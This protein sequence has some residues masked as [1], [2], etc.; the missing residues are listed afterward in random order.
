[1]GSLEMTEMFVCKLSFLAVYRCTFLLYD[2]TKWKEVFQFVFCKCCE[3]PHQV[4]MYISPLLLLSI[5]KNVIWNSFQKH[6]FKIG[7][8]CWIIIQSKNTLKCTA[9]KWTSQNFSLIKV[10]RKKNKDLLS[11][12]IQQTSTI[13]CSISPLLL[14][15]NPSHCTR[16]HVFGF[17]AL[18][19]S[20][21]YCPWHFSPSIT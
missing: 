18:M 3:L 9:F 17:L 8:N 11:I 13:A 2:M 1:M 21:I 7:I 10:H 19:F 14:S 6:S 5:S 12:K 4:C 16:S 20:F 15:L